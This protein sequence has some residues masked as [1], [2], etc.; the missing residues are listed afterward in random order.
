M[1]RQRRHRRGDTIL[2]AESRMLAGRLVAADLLCRARRAWRRERLLLGLF[3][4]VPCPHPMR[5][6]IVLFATRHERARWRSVSAFGSMTEW[7]DRHAR[8]AVPS[9]CMSMMK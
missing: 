4:S 2:E 8:R 1:K 9:V 5:K 7:F 6:K 3:R